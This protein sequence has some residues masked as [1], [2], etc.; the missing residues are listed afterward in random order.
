M[1]HYETKLC[2]YTS[3]VTVMAE[4]GR[5]P[6]TASSRGK[7]APIKLAHVVFR[8]GRYKKMIDWYK[9]VLEAEI[10]YDN[11]F[12]TFLTYDE[13][14]HR[15]AIARA[16]ALLPKLRTQWGVDHIAFT[17]E[18]IADLLSTYQRLKAEGISPYWCINHG[19]TTSMYYKDPDNNHVEL[20]IDNFAS[21]DEINDFLDGPEFSNNPIG[22]DFDPDELVAR[23]EAGESHQDLT[24]WR[25][26]RSRGSGT[27][28]IAYLGWVQGTLI[29][30]AAKLGLA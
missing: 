14:H 23:F 24:R 7:V 9:L 8:T 1:V 30:L 22:V 6:E 15:I 28:P 2:N 5:M 25:D 11:E 21:N 12:I 27:I 3:V 19:G 17:Y 20:Q 4:K 29:K 13:E 18:N 26:L 10:M 16:P